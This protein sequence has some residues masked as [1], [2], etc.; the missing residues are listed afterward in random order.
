MLT[1]TEL[2]PRPNYKIHGT[3]LLEDFCVTVGTTAHPF[4]FR[5]WDSKISLSFQGSCQEA[6]VDAHAVSKARNFV[7]INNYLT[8]ALIL[9]LPLLTVICDE[10]INDF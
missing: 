1:R 2:G 5:N 6:L 9:L 3:I 10:L 4:F 8:V 7:L